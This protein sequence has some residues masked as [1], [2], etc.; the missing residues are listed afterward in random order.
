MSHATPV[1]VAAALGS[2]TPVV[3]VKPVV[4]PSPG[5]GV[6]LR[7]RISAPVT[8]TDLPVVV[9]VHGFGS[10][11]EGYGPLT[12]HWA[13]RGFVVVQA[14]HLDSRT[15]AIP[16]DDPRSADFW[17]S[18]VTDV[19]HLL[20]RLDDLVATVPGLPDRVDG[21]RIAVAGHSFGGQTAG[22][23]LGLRVLPPAGAGEDMSDPRITAGVLL[24]TAGT[25][26]DDLTPLAREHFGYL[27]PDFSHLLTPALV[28]AGDRDQ[29]LL[30]VRGPDWSEDPHRLSPGP[31][32]LLRLHG[33]EH[34]LGGIP[35]YDAAETTDEDPARV[36]FLQDLT[37][38][39]LRSA[40]HP[41]DTSWTEAVAALE[42][43]PDP[44]GDVESR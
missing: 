20:D 8:G 14:T 31:T 25:G 27:N 12:D 15:L 24:A 29:S 10:S 13:S 34:S 23:L 32:S 42:H 26:G 1:S 19:T 2:P 36:A 41:G 38:A 44:R 28:V 11:L 37:T 43:E 3:S 6:D 22:I 9:F 21:T 17:R 33:A 18:R 7:V 40:L 30:S 4:L 5:R 16:P 35:G 39:Y